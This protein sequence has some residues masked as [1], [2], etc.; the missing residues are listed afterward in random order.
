MKSNKEHDDY[1]YTQDH[2]EW[3]MEKEE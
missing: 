1:E 2:E 3:V